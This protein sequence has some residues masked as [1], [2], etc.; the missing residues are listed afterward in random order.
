VSEDFGELVGP[1]DTAMVVITTAAADERAGCLVGF[2]SQCSIDPPRYAVWLSKA[3]HTYRVVLHAGHLAVHLLTADDVDVAEHFG[4]Q[5]GDD[6]DKFADIEWDAGPDGVPLLRRLP[7]RLVLRRHTL[8]DD[9]SDH[10][11]L[12]GVP[13][14]VHGAEPFTPLRLSDVSH[15]DAGH[16]VE[17]RPVPPT[18]RSGDD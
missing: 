1:L 12:V 8:L 3:N 7:H 10:V 6:T 13:V 14:A 11:C 9:G 2:H 15:L 4:T 5:S 16:G 18:E 17:E